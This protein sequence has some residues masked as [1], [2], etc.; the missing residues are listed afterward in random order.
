MQVAE[1]HKIVSSVKTSQGSRW[2]P[3]IVVEIPN[4][5]TRISVW[6]SGE[7]RRPETTSVYIRVQMVMSDHGGRQAGWRKER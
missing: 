1:R 2:L 4:G 6:S 5:Q 7:N 3:N